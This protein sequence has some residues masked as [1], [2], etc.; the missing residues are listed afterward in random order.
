MHVRVRVHVHMRVHVHVRVHV[1]MHMRVRVHVRVR[2]R[3]HV[4]VHVHVCLLDY[5]FICLFDSKTGTRTHKY[6]PLT[7]NIVIWAPVSIQRLFVRLCRIWP[8]TRT[9]IGSL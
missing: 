4:R 2:V 7:S 9:A 6:I 5:L 1:H 3:V 8:V